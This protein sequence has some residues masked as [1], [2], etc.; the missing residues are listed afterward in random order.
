M[1]ATVASEFLA[2]SRKYLLKLSRLGII[3]GHPLGIGSR[4]QWRY[5]ISE[6]A[7]WALAQNAIWPDNDGGSPRVQ[8]GKTK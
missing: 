6:L 5:R 2:V 7:E 1:D 8:K 4:R 3:P